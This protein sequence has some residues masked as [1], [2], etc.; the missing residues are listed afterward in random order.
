V[1]PQHQAFVNAYL[2]EAKGNGT[3]AAIIAGYSAHTAGVQASQLLKRKD[4]QEAVRQRLDRADL[5]TQARLERLGKIADHEPESI[6]AADVIH[7]NKLILQVNGALKEKHSEPRITVNIGFLQQPQSQPAIEV[8]TEA[9]A[10]DAS[11][12]N[13]GMPASAQVLGELG[14]GPGDERS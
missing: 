4:I 6:T 13:P 10:I 2:G 1:K 3:K 8:T 9:R 5:R 7:A 11:T 14:S 12:D